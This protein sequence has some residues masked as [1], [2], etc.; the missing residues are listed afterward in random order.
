MN[1]HQ[2]QRLIEELGDE[3]YRD[4]F[5]MDVVNGFIASQIKAN[6][7]GRGWTQK[8]LGERV[9]MKQSRISVLEDVNYESWSLRTLRRI[10]KAFGLVLSVRFV[11][12]GAALKEYASFSKDRL[13]QPPMEEE[14]A[15]HQADAATLRA[16]LAPPGVGEMPSGGLRLTPGATSGSDLLVRMSRDG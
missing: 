7:E 6:R 16:S 9:E 2:K 3:E 13:Y 10:A 1:H 14:E 12:V 8:E 5:F 4:V 11:S 15:A